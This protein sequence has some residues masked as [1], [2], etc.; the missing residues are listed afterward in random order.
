M[1]CG[2]CVARLRPLPFG[3]LIGVVPVCNRE[4]SSSAEGFRRDLDSWRCLA[5]LVLVPIHQPDYSIHDIGLE[6]ARSYFFRWPVFFNVSFKDRI[7]LEDDE[8]SWLSWN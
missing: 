7:E 2:R 3:G 6:T 4:A 8:S 1:L 5:A